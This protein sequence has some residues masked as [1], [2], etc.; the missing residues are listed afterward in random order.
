MLANQARRF[1]ETLV[2]RHVLSRDDLEQA[3]DESERTKEPLPSV[4]LR[5]DLV[6][7]K[8]LTAALAEQMGVR[9]IDF[10]ETP[11]HQDAP[12]TLSAEL[13]RQ[14]VAVPVD[15]EGQKLVVAFAEPPSDT[16]LTAVGHATS[17]EVIP[18]V[19]DR[20]ELMRAIAMIY[21][22]VDG[23]TP[24]F[25]TNVV[26]GEEQLDDELHIN[27]LLDLV[28]QWG[29]SDLHLA[30]G[31]PPVIRVNGDLRPV[32]EL[33]IFNGSQ[34][35][36]M[37]FSIL[38]QKQ[39][40]KFENELELDTSYA[41]PGR[42]RFRVNVFVQRDSVGCVMRA[43][44]YDIV[45]FERL[46]I[47]P[48]VQ[49]WAHLPRG[50]VLVTGPTGSGKST[51]LASLID[52]VNRERSVH[53]MTVEDPIEFLHQHKR[54]LI[55]QREVGEDT[56][57]FAAALKHVL[58]QDPDVILVGEMR[59]LETISTALTAAETGHLVFATLHTQDAQQSIDRVIDV[60]PAHQQQQVR[61]QLASALQGICTQ[62]LLPTVDG[63]GRAVA[64]EVMVA[65]PAI[66][67]LIREGKTHQIY[68]ML[69]AGGRYG[70]V[71]MDMSLAQ[72]V[73]ARSISVET[74]LERCA[75][76]EDLRR[77]LNG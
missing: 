37:V 40:E 38:T 4:L 26:V 15:F 65:T 41:L 16:A 27:D 69:Q 3:I 10:L 1:G 50:L 45:D 57:S 58:R 77:L 56:H 54:S 13:A 76:E 19:A 73:R 64:C 63:Q 20:N 24:E 49:G 46:G 34:I 61:V 14:F 12:E 32:T 30:S 52:I 55:N 23:D 53:I 75:N 39:R 71:T 43:I 25:G 42:G 68:S 31:S 6:G 33:P 60:F 29:G 59:D 44:P 5:L 11:I 47:A 2:D 67:N 66:R 62:Q 17:F 35:R 21:G 18:A 74:A 72:L 7:S 28:I 48:A 22:A 36:Q 70:M 9:F 51:T 8:D